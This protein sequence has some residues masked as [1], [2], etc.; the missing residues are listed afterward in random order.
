MVSQ[1]II[2]LNDRNRYKG[3]GHTVLLIQ[4]I[5][6]K[7]NLFYYG[8]DKVEFK[9]I[10]DTS[11]IEEL[12]KILNTT[13][14]DRILIKGDF[15]ESYTY[16]KNLYLRYKNSGSNTNKFYNKFLNNCSHMCWNVLLQ[17]FIN[18]ISIKEIINMHNIKTH[19]V[20]SVSTR[21]VQKL[22]QLIGGS[23]NVKISC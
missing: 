19:Y 5:N 8:I 15:S 13:Y 2:W 23:N 3:L 21:R 1:N 22:S 11:T 6:Q 17:G 20:P 12:N 18:R 7:W 4:D 14:T 16:C 10:P 9:Q